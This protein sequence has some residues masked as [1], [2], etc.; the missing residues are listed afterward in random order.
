MPDSTEIAGEYVCVAGDIWGG[1]SFKL[2]K[3][4]FFMHRLI[5][6]NPLYSDLLVFTGGERL[7]IPVIS[8]ADKSHF[9]AWRN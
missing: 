3:S 2:F 8:D 9:A 6:A 5:S 4:E 1:I 7:K